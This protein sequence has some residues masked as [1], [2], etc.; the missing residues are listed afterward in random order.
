MEDFL[1]KDLTLLKK[2][3]TTFLKKIKHFSKIQIL[4][5]LSTSFLSQITNRFQILIKKNLDLNKKTLPNS[6]ILLKH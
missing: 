4:K 2:C 3:V 5:N 6:L 1:S